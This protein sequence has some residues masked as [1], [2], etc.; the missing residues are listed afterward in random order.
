[1]PVAAAGWLV[2]PWV[3][4]RFFPQYLASVPAVRWSLLSGLVWSLAP[5]AQ[6]L[7]SLKAWGSLAVYIGLLLATRWAFPWA[8]SATGDPL[9]GVARGNFAA[10]VV[11]GA[12]S[13]VLVFRATV[14]PAATTA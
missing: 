8:F 5:A 1:V 7:G 10:A 11:T 13:L 2:A 4:G 12:I 14:G 6:V 9:E 3:I